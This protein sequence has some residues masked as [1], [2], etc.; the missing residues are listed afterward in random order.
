[1]NPTDSAPPPRAITSAALRVFSVPELAAYIALYLR[2][3]EQLKLSL[4]SKALRLA[5]PPALKL[6]VSSFTFSTETTSDSS[7]SDKNSDG[8]VFV[9]SPRTIRHLA[10]RVRS[11][12]LELHNGTSDL[13]QRAMLNVIFESC[14]ESLEDLTIRY[15][16]NDTKVLEEVLVN[17][18]GILSLSVHFMASINAME[19]PK[20]LT[21]VRRT[22]RKLATEQEKEQEQDVGKVKKKIHDLKSLKIQSVIKHYVNWPGFVEML[23]SCPEL[24]TLVL[25]DMSFW[26]ADVSN[27]VEGAESWPLGDE[28]SKE[29]QNTE[30]FN[31]TL[32]PKLETLKLSKCNIPIEQFWDMDE[33][34]PRLKALIMKGCSGPWLSAMTDHYRPS[35]LDGV[36]ATAP[37]TGRV[38]FAQLRSLTLWIEFQSGRARILSL[39]NGRPYMETLETDVLPDKRDGLF[40]LAGYSSG[41]Q[42]S[43]SSISGDGNPSP[44]TIATKGSDTATRIRHKFKRLAL[45]TYVSPA[46]SVEELE[47][48]YGAQCFQ[49]LEY[50]YMQIRELSTGLFAFAKTL[51]HL[52]LGG[53]SSRLLQHEAMT[54]NQVLRG[55]PQLEILKVERYMDSYQAF[56]GLGREAAVS[57]G[58]RCAPGDNSD[59]SQQEENTRVDWFQERPFL[60]ELEIHICGST[61][62]LEC[63]ESASNGKILNVSELQ[64]QVIDRFRFLE[65]IKVYLN[66]TIAL[67]ETE[68][69]ESWKNQ[70]WTGRGARE[71]MIPCIEMVHL[72]H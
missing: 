21:K 27:A 16:G 68:E 18:P 37:A 72:H 48:F 28:A 46:Y 29:E 64:R 58:D 3:F 17:L 6:S 25:K 70:I 7:K 34:F 13:R 35:P 19:F 36:T 60:R 56:S 57:A 2:P 39:L 50:V 33:A 38:A 8:Q 32:F 31:S 1:M 61:S 43:D 47:E 10:P 14:S 69:L 67:P 63:P 26:R 11:L 49:E 30:Y 4:I 5:F 51:R 65:R 53:E 15:W 62:I 44:G 41:S 71:C 66:P 55:L 20:A 45:Q 59:A 23:Q 9:S 52:H 24:K 54:L 42:S 12:Y 40:E 22:I